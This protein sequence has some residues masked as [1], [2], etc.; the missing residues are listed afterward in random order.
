MYI[1]YGFRNIY[2]KQTYIKG[3]C[4][5]QTRAFQDSNIYNINIASF[6][7]VEYL[8]VVFRKLSLSMRL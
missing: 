6:W 4:I 1:I 5:G 2:D 3:G 7:Q 8:T